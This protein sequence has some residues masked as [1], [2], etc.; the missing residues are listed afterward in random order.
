MSNYREFGSH[1]K[2]KNKRQKLFQNFMLIFPQ[3]FFYADFCS[4]GMSN[5]FP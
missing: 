4:E 2:K 1:D 3:I 5:V